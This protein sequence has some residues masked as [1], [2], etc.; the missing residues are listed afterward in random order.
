L[1]KSEKPQVL[2]LMTAEKACTSSY[3]TYILGG[4][5]DKEAQSSVSGYCS[6]SAAIKRKSYSGTALLS[7]GQISILSYHNVSDI[8][9]LIYLPHS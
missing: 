5:K 7:V 6:T 2:E 9:Q 3:I 1:A 8:E 4:S